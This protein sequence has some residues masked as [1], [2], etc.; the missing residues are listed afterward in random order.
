MSLRPGCLTRSP[1]QRPTP[2]LGQMRGGR[3]AGRFPISQ[4][5]AEGRP[6]EVRGRTAVQGRDKEGAE[7]RSVAL[8]AVTGHKH[9]LRIPN[10][11]GQGLG[12]GEAPAPSAGQEG[13][14]LGG[15]RGRA[16]QGCGAAGRWGRGGAVVEGR[17]PAGRWA[18]APPPV[19]G[20]SPTSLK[21]LCS[22]PHE[23][24]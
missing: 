14:R 8:P 4:V 24:L 9:C 19:P 12:C 16:Q 13:G 6:P 1:A 23:P 21:E 15:V 2:S 20:L 22:A 11:L 18:D 7:G 5:S 10:W 17:E 3:G